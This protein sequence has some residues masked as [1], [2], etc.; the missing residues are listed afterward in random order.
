MYHEVYNLWI[1]NHTITYNHKRTFSNIK[2]TL[3]TFKNYHKTCHVLHYRM[4]Y[5]NSRMPTASLL[6]K[7]SPSKLLSNVTTCALDTFNDKLYSTE[8]TDFVRSRN[9]LKISSDIT[10]QF[11]LNKRDLKVGKQNTCHKHLF[12]QTYLHLTS[13]S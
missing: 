1:C 7:T 10:L 3:Q 5:N 13:W 2:K 6:S 8:N 12:L 11:P 4:I 9:P